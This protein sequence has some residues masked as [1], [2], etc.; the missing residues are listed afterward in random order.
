MRSRVPVVPCGAKFESGPNQ[1]AAH[2]RRERKDTSTA[3][4]QE[5]IKESERD[6]YSIKNERR[7]MRTGTLLC[8][9]RTRSLTR[10]R[11]RQAF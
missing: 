5:P 6:L 9:M 1:K 3:R 8:T 2:R 11:K 4:T 10:R 7:S